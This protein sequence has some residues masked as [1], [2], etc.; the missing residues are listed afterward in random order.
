MIL[1]RRDIYFVK[2]NFYSQVFTKCLPG[3]LSRDLQIDS[4]E[5]ENDDADD[6][7][8]IESDLISVIGP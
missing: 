4:M 6:I 5:T 8:T 1:S 2:T 3:A 7:R